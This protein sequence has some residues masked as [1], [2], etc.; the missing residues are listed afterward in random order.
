MG[1]RVEYVLNEMLSS[2][3]IDYSLLLLYFSP[4]RKIIFLPLFLST[5]HK[6]GEAQ[7]TQMM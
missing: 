6:F 1:V 2:I 5:L 4:H 3:T 7:S